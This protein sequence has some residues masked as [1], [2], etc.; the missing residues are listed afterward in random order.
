MT[1]NTFFKTVLT[2]SD[3]VMGRRENKHNIACCGGKKDYG[4]TSF[5]GLW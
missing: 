2:Y 4:N 1:L 3:E 5:G